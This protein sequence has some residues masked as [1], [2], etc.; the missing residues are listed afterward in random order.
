[1]S[2]VVGLPIDYGGDKPIALTI[3][4]RQECGNLH[5]R[6]KELMIIIIHQS[7]F[8]SCTKLEVGAE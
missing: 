5:V 2:I 6:E 3:Y 4:L 1:M 8:I 7:Y